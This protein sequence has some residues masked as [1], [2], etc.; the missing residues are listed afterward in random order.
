VHPHLYGGDKNFRRNLYEKFVN[1]PPVHQVHSQ[2]EQETIF[3]TYF[4]EIWRSVLLDS[5]LRATTK[6]GQLFKEKSVPSR[7]NPGYAYSYRR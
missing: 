2:A 6:K 4:A 7:Q 3:R 1:A 5:L